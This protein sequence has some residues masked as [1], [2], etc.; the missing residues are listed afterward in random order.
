[1]RHFYVKLKLRNN[2]NNSNNNNN[3]KVERARCQ[4]AA[5]PS[6]RKVMQTVAEKN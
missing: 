2:N 3:N 4:L 1:M 6:H 5:I